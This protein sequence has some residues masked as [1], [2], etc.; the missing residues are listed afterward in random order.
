M[1]DFTYCIALIPVIVLHSSYN[2]IIKSISLQFTNRAI[3]EKLH[4][5]VT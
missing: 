5:V 3:M 4:T 2:S 1:L